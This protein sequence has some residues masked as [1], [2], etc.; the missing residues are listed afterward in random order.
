[1]D[2]RY[3]WNNAHQKK[4]SNLIY[5]YVINALEDSLEVVC[6]I[7]LNGR[8]DENFKQYAAFI[9]Q[10]FNHMEIYISGTANVYEFTRKIQC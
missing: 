3:N 2:E 8:E 9:F 10:T 4:I 7:S 5:E 1:M 6:F